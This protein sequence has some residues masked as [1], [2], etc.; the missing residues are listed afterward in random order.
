MAKCVAR[1]SS[2]YPLRQLLE[3]TPNQ[4]SSVVQ[5]FKDLIEGEADT[6]A[7][8]ADDE[9]TEQVQLTRI[10]KFPRGDREDATGPA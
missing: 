6:S 1:L 2:E 7:T 10:S 3:G 4:L 9:T 5:M 8:P